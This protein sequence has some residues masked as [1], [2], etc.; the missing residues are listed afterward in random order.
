MTRAIVAVFGVVVV[1]T[2]LLA[3]LANGYFSGDKLL[4]NRAWIVRGATIA[5]ASAFT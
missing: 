3:T 4:A 1:E 5:V 2:L